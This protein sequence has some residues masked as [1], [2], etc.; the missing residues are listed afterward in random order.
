MIVFIKELNTT[1]HANANVVLILKL[2]NVGLT[3]FYATVSRME[4]FKQVVCKIHMKYLTA[5]NN[6]KRMFKPSLS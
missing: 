1:L 3:A 5:K 2:K 4:V 6:I